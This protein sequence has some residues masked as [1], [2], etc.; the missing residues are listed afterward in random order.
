M[1]LSEVHLRLLNE[2]CDFAFANQNLSLS[3]L[4]EETKI[5][6]SLSFKKKVFFS[7]QFSIRTCIDESDL[8]CC[9]LQSHTKFY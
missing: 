6:V 9:R 5:L 1:N 3:F 7:L 4:K 8:C 2:E